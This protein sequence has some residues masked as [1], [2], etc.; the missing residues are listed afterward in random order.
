VAEAVPVTFGSDIS[1]QG[2]GADGKVVLTTG[3]AGGS[4]RELGAGLPFGSPIPQVRE[5]TVY[6]AASN[7]PP[8][9]KHRSVTLVGPEGRIQDLRVQYVKDLPVPTLVSPG[10]LAKVAGPTTV[11]EV[12]LKLAPGADRAQTLDQVT[13]IAILGGQLEVSGATILDLRV[14]SA[15]ATARAA[16][17]AI[18]AIAV[19]VAVIGAAATA[20]LSVSE[21]ARTHAMLRAIGLERTGLHR[22]LSVRLTLVATV[23]ACFGVLAGGFLGVIA[24]GAVAHTIDLAP[25]VAIPVLPI[26]AVVV[27]TVFAVRLAALVPVE[28]ASYIPPSRALSQA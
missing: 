12:W 19:L 1:V 9:F 13:G 11:N 15:F 10:T 16:A 17:V 24:G 27:L 3:T 20:A 18:L 5:D 14:E 26:V 21:R 28:R 25:H 8:F 7:F 4:A 23:A 22:L 2:H 6:I